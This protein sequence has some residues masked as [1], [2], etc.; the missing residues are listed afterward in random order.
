MGLKDGE[1]GAEE[2]VLSAVM[3][4]AEAR[5][6]AQRLTAR[7]GEDIVIDAAAVDLLG[8]P[9]AQVLLSAF[10]TWHADGRSIDL[11]TPSEGFRENARLLGM[12]QL[13]TGGI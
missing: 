1:D 12:T 13:L 5:P 2:I 10:K 9:C 6:L 3:N 4:L 7:R 11:R 8:A